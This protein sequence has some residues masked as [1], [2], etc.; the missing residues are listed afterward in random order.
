MKKLCYHIILIICFSQQ[1]SAQDIHV[2]QFYETPLMRNPALAGI[3]TGHVRIQSVH[4][5]QWSFTGF[6]YQT[7]ALSG[8]YK[9]PVGYGYD[10]M[11]V[12]MQTFYDV[13]GNTRL[14]TLQVMPAL[15]FHKALSG[16]KTEYLS[17]G[18]MVGMVQRQ[19]DLNNLTFN[20]QYVNGEFNQ[21]ASSGESFSSVNRKVLD[22]AAG[23][24]YNSE[25][26]ESGS[27]YLGASL[28]HINQPTES[29]KDDKIQLP[30]K[31]QINAGL[32]LKMTENMDMVAELNYSK[33]GSYNEVMLGGI[34][35]FQLNDNYTNTESEEGLEKISLGIG[36]FI[37]LQD[38][39]TPVVKMTYKR[40]EIGVSYDVN[41]SD[42]KKGSQGR[43]GYELSLSYKFSRPSIELSKQFC[44]RF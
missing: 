9:F 4:R 31:T 8:E 36:G 34:W 38:A 25:I 19:F 27:Y 28:Y 10:F 39:F 7:T 1:L 23:L 21:N 6:G 41:L 18:F 37:R 26:G 14:K 17:G 35:S 3:F 22:M 42:L 2:S 16:T 5:T 43:G 32:H 13:A 40:T 33:Q 44:P 11:T 29:F 12:G 20:N 15:N 24:S 30:S